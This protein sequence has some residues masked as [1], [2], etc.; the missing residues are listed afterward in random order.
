M[1][2][3][4]LTKVWINL[5]AT[6]AAVSA[7]SAPARSR[8]HDQTGNVRTYAGGRQRSITQVGEHGAF[9]FTLRDVSLTTIDTLRLWIGLSVQVRDHRSQRFFGVYYAVPITEAR[10]P[11]LYDV[12]IA[13]Q[14]ITAVEGV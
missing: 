1:A 5:M 14:T 7:Y 8:Q 4:D 11:T 9:S 10:E 2:Q 3:L 6:G 13:L 12:T